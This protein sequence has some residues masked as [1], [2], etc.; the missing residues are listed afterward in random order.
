MNRDQALDTFEQHYARD[1]ILTQLGPDAEHMARDFR[2]TDFFRNKYQ[3]II[4]DNRDVIRDARLLDV[5]ANLGHWSTLC[6]LNGARSITCLEPRLRYV[7]GI[8]SFAR[9]HSLAME[10]VQGIHTDCA[11]MGR[12]FDVVMLGAMVSQMP[13]VWDFFMR[14]R[15]ITEHVIVGHHITDS[16]L[17]DDACRLSPQVNMNN[18]N[19]VDLRHQD[20]KHDPEGVQYDWSSLGDGHARGQT[21]HWYYGIDFLKSLVRHL[22]YDVVREV[23]HDNG[24]LFGNTLGAEPSQTLCDLVLRVRR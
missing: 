11:G 7:D 5:G 19:A 10:A 18:R 20:W 4:A 24:L 14:L 21:F 13:D 1:L 12:K 3:S 17:P 15:D 2:I 22:G 16:S 8:N 23:R 6:N 9:K